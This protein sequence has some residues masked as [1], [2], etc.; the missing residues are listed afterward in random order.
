LQSLF[1]VFDVNTNCEIIV[2]IKRVFG[3]K[4]TVC[5]IWIKGHYKIVRSFI[6]KTIKF[7]KKLTLYPRIK[8][9]YT[10]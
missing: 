10:T 5:E 2:R 7:V 9:V 1:Y 6:I 4:Q 8:N 3:K